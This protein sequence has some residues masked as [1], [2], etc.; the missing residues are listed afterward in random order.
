MAGQ[1][2]VVAAAAAVGETSP[3]PLTPARWRTATTCASWQR[4]TARRSSWRPSRRT[5]PSPRPRPPA[6]PA[7][8]P[9]A[10][11]SPP[12]PSLTPSSSTPSTTHHRR[13]GPM[14]AGPP[15]PWLVGI[16]APAVVVSEA[17]RGLGV[18]E[19]AEAWAA[20][21]PSQW[22]AHPHLLERPWIPT[23]LPPARQ[24]GWLVAVVIL[25]LCEVSVGHLLLRQ[26]GEG[27]AIGREKKYI[28]LC[29]CFLRFVNRGL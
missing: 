10:A 23:R 12:P 13:M 24:V 26:W 28:M 21:E 4:T 1:V 3:P 20:V 16:E 6:P 18:E 15:P 25:A 2:A 5:T 17:W 9:A 7:S 11:P 29:V 19:V 22:E 14:A 8:H 27:V